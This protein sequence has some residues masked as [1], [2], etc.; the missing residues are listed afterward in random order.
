V[1]VQALDTAVNR[2]GT[3][4]IVMLIGGEKDYLTLDCSPV[5]WTIAPFIKDSDNAESQD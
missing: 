1:D 2:M 4:T 3:D 5:W